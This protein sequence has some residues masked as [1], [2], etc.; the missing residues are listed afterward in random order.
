MKWP[1]LSDDQTLVVLASV[2][3]V[4]GLAV[5]A[6]S[7]PSSV[8][9]LGD[10]VREI[11]SAFVTEPPAPVPTERF[12]PYVWT[13]SDLYEVSQGHLVPKPRL[14]R[15]VRASFRLVWEGARGAYV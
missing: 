9:N 7:L 15:W 5:I 11:V 2:A 13:L 6:L 12:V 4:A 14:P 10:K 3:A 1:K 8:P